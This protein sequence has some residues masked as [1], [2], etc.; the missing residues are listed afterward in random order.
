MGTLNQH[1]QVVAT[2][3]QLAS[4]PLPLVIECTH[5]ASLQ[6]VLGNV[7]WRV[8][9]CTLNRYS[10]L[11]LPFQQ[12]FLRPTPG[13]KDIGVHLRFCWNWDIDTRLI[14]CPTSEPTC[15]RVDIWSTTTT[16]A[17]AATAFFVHQSRTTTTTSAT[18]EYELP[19][20]AS[21]WSTAAATTTA[22]SRSAE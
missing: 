11:N 10:T 20:T 13:W 22:S 2:R 9:L 3:R 21:Y 14:W 16:P 4:F 18:A 6:K 8:S 19:R 5:I 15:A 17:A 7:I 12:Q 1:F